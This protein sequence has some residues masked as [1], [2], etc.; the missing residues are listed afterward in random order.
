MPLPAKLTA[1]QKRFVEEYMVDLNATQAAIRA[2]YSK[3]SAQIIGFENL[4]K[5]IVADKI[6][7]LARE[8][9][10]KTAVT[11]ERV[12]AEMATVA[13]TN[14]ANYFS[15]GA[16]GSPCLDFSDLSPEQTAA[17]SEITV[18]HYLVGKGEDARPAIRTKLKLHDKMRALEQ[19]GKYLA[20]FVTRVEHQGEVTIQHELSDRERMRRLAFFMAEDKAAGKLPEHDAQSKTLVQSKPV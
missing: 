13:Y 6:T 20:L 14:M 18:H 16:D 15:V 1:K 7:E 10:A 4:S 17:I 8:L 3:T 12:V 2:G 19:L 11:A 9:S 5:P